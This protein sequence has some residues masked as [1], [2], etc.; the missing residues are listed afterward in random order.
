LSVLSTHTLAV[1]DCFREPFDSG[2]ADLVRRLA[3]PVEDQRS[4]SYVYDMAFE[5]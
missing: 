2:G 1:S 5:E 4:S 3:V